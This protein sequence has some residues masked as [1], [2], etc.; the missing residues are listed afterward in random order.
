MYTGERLGKETVGRASHSRARRANRKN[1]FTSR[2]SQAKVLNKNEKIETLYNEHCHDCRTCTFA[3]V[4]ASL[5]F[6]ANSFEANSNANRSPFYLLFYV[7]LVEGHP[8]PT[9]INDHTRTGST[10]ATHDDKIASILQSF[11]LSSQHKQD[12]ASYF[13]R[14]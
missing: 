13:V 1:Y 9:L 14:E 12:L 3:C 2:S 6:L 4:N 8:Y 10:E 5:D 11:L 7:G